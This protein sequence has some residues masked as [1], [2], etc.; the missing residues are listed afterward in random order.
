M[1]HLYISYTSAK[2]RFA[3]GVKAFLSNQSGVT[4]IEYGL[5]AALVG[6]AIVAGATS[7]GT[8]LSSTFTNIAGTLSKA[9]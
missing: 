4:A 1:L 5:I 6:V 8:T 7:L 2:A 9:I 3:N